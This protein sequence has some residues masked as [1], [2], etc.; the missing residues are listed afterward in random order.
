MRMPTVELSGGVPMPMAGLGTARLLGEP[1]YAAVREALDVGYRLVDTATAYR[2]EPEVGRA[3]RDS[4]V[5]RSEVF[6]TTKLPPEEAGRE[7]RVLDDSLR[8]LG[9]DHVDLWLVHWPP[10][11]RATVRTWEAFLAAREAGKARAV[12]V[13]NHTLGQLDELTAATG[14]AP[15]VNQVPW[16]PSRHDPVTLA[17]SRERGVVVEGYSPLSGTNLAEPALA[18][19]A[20]AHGVTAARVVLRWHLH[21]GIVVIPK[22]GDPARLRANLDLWTFALTPEEIAAIDALAG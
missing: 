7:T 16:S 3:L 14:I 21:H 12:G 9:V 19:V 15:A 4:G 2:N 20:D 13:S 6:V 10:G 11:G 5:D 18:A 1:G 8:A 17:A 22:S